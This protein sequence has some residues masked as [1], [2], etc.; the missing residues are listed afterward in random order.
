MN[1]KAAIA[2]LVLLCAASSALKAGDKDM[3]LC[4]FVAPR[5]S[6][7][8]RTAVIQGVV[9]VKVDIDSDGIPRSIDALEG[10]PLLRASAVDAVK[11]WRFCS[12]S[13]APGNHQVTITFRFKL[14]GKG[15]D[16]WVATEIGFQS[17]ATVDITT[18]P[19]GPLWTRYNP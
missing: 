12:S 11:N 4:R 17:P 15:T 9:R 13:E 6:A 7:V 10:H 1:V 2:I 5:Y 18:S 14:E 3:C 19:P 16:R 8:A